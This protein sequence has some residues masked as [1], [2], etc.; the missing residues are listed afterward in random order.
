[1]TV[2]KEGNVYRLLF[3]Q[4]EKSPSVEEGKKNSKKKIFEQAICVEN[5]QSIDIS[6]LPLRPLAIRFLKKLQELNYAL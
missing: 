4:F 6:M 5:L 3:E 2:F 1:L